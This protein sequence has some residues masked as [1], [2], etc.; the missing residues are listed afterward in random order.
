VRLII[1]DILGREII[2]LVNEQVLPG[3]YEVEWNSTYYPP[4][5]RQAPSGVYFYK[6]TADS[7]SESKNMILI[8]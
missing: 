1:Y 5:G 8:K 2:T 6:L 7:Y 3:T 4:G